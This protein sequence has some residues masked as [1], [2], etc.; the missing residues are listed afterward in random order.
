MA[1]KSTL[2][3]EK[4]TYSLLECDYEF[5]QAIDI[6]GRPSD[7]PRGGILRLTLVSPDDSDL[8]FHEWMKEK[9]LVKD[10][11]IILTVNKNGDF[12]DK[13]IHFTDAYCI[14]LHEYFNDANALPMY[15][16]LSI[17]AGSITFGDDCTFKMID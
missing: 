2:T 11:D 5:T 8:L 13:R 10:G 14:R 7:R 6:T 3:I 15:T 17:M 4:K 12:A 1:L 16:E 9:D